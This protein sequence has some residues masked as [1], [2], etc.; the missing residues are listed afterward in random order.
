MMATQVLHNNQEIPNYNES[1]DTN[2]VNDVNDVTSI[3]SEATSEFDPVREIAF[4]LGV[5]FIKYSE[6]EEIVPIKT[7]DKVIVKRAIWKEQ[8]Q[9]VA[10]KH[11]LG[12]NEEEIHK[13]LETE[14][15]QKAAKQT[16]MEA[17]VIRKITL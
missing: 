3:I 9:E 6:F 11:I 12:A 7:E 8:L 2:D 16:S 1:N 4:Q 15:I 14:V 13:K 10:L 5:E 17:N